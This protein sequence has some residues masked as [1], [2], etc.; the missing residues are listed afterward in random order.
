M[1]TKTH[2]L[3]LLGAAIASRVTYFSY[4]ADIPRAEMG[5]IASTLSLRIAYI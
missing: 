5:N 2:A 3:L 1:L 4:Q